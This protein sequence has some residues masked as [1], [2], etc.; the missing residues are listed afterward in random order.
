M[1]LTDII[2][3]NLDL[4]SAVP[5]DT[6]YKDFA[7]A[8]ARLLK[9]DYGSHNFKPFMEVLHA[10]LGIGETL[11]EIQ[12]SDIEKIDFAFVDGTSRLYGVYVYLKNGKGKS[13]DRKLRGKSEADEFLT[14]LGIDIK[15]EL[16]NMNQIID[17]LKAKGIKAVESEYDVS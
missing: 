3:E 7:K 10:E 2:F 17:A 4:S 11:N 16:S 12:S 1:K 8:V 5:E 6:N 9:N 15:V 14:S 13:W